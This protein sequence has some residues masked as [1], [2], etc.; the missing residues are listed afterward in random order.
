[1]YVRACVHVCVCVCVS[2]PRWHLMHANIE[3]LVFASCGPRQH[4]ELPSGLRT[5]WVPP[6]KISTL[7]Y[8]DRREEEEDH[9]R[10]ILRGI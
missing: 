5:G 7:V 9:M 6:M 8:S 4:E 1:M 10:R 3:S 2:D